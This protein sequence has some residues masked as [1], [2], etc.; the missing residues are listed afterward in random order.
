MYPPLWLTLHMYV[1]MRARPA[2][3]PISATTRRALA[4][5]HSL[6]AF[7]C[8]YAGV[9]THRFRVQR[10]VVNT[11]G[12]CYARMH[13]R[14]RAFRLAV[15]NAC[16]ACMLYTFA[17]EY[18]LCLVPTSVVFIF[19]ESNKYA[20]LLRLDHVRSMQFNLAQHHRDP[21]VCDLATD[22][23]CQKPNLK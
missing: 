21:H 17:L 1:C 9:I 11:N 5:S 20:P 3:V 14:A 4:C 18:V 2:L 13:S 19:I 22:T 23:P 10:S 7:E 6:V 15:V 12:I 16:S 8:G